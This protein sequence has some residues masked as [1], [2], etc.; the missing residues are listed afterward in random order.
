VRR[1]DPHFGEKDAYGQR[2]V[3]DCVIRGPKGEAAVRTTWIILHQE[4]APRL[5][6]CYV[7]S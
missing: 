4:K 6:S 2:Y 5:T 7:L 1:E 3:L